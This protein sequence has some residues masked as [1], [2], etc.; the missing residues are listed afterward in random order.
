MQIA[1][2]SLFKLHEPLVCQQYFTSIWG[3]VS[4]TEKNVYNLRIKDALFKVA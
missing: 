4:L 3:F 1:G 2:V